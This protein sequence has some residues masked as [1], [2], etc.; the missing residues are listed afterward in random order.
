MTEQKQPN[1]W[2]EQYRPRL[3]DDIIGHETIKRFLRCL[4]STTNTTKIPDLIFHGPP[5]TGKTSSAIAFASEMYPGIELNTYSMYL[6]ASDERTIETV[7]E[8]IREF[9]KIQWSTP[10][11]KIIILDEIETMTE[12]AQLSLRS[13]MDL[14]DTPHPIFIFLCNTL[15]KIVPS[16]RSRALSLYFNH[17]SFTQIHGLI[18]SIQKKEH[19]QTPLPKPLACLLYRGDLRSFIQNAQQETNPNTWLPWFQRLFN[20]P[21]E[22]SHIVWEDGFDCL[23]PRI[24]L[25]HVLVFCY[26]IGVSTIDADTWTHWLTIVIQSRT[27]PRI[28]VIVPAWN[29][30]IR[31]LFVKVTT[32][33][34]TLCL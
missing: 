21:P 12:P 25:R 19:K 10:R 32:P 14:S 1:Q 26:S 16:I 15:S 5:G 6:N 33:A 23:P 4:I 18:T 3:I 29:S 17:L 31:A 9:L 30:V 8:R 13:L 11:H 34:H 22:L 2:T 20:A 7:R 24:L 28:D 27:V